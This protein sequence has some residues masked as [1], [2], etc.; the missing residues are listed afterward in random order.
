MLASDYVCPRLMVTSLS[1]LSAS[2]TQDPGHI[3]S[4]L[5][6]SEDSSSQQGSQS[7]HESSLEKV[8]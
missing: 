3:E 1:L 7:Y 4:H 8:F 2:K 6:D 5:V